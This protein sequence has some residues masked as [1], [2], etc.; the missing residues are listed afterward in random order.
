MVLNQCQEVQYRQQSHFGHGYVRWGIDMLLSRSQIKDI[1]SFDLCPSTP[2]GTSVLTLPI[3]HKDGPP[4]VLFNSSGPGDRIHHPKN[5]TAVQE[6]CRQ[7]GV[8]CKVYGSKQ[9]GLPEVP[10]GGNIY[11]IVMKV[12]FKSWN[13]PFPGDKTTG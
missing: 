8:D 7:L 2:I 12:F 13:L 9:S 10:K 5:A 11:D 4:I 6:R 1:D 3:L